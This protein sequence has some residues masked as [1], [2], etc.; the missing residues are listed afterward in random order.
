MKKRYRLKKWV[1]YFLLIIF[2]G[3]LIYS[4]I[5]ILVWNKGV[6]ENANTKEEIKKEIKV[7]ENTEKSGDVP[8]IDY[9]VNF[10]KLK[11][12]NSDAVGYLIVK[13]TNIDYVVVKAED[14]AYYLNHD[15]NKKNNK[16]GWIFADFKNKFDGN[17]KNIVIYGHNTA[18]GS[19]FGT[20]KN[21]FN[22]E[23]ND[24]LKEQNA[25]IYF[26]TSKGTEYYKIF[27]SYS[28]IPEDYYITTDFNS[29]S[30]YSEFLKTI[31]S[32]SIYS[33]G[34]SVDTNDT[35]LTLS[36]CTKNGTKRVAL[37]AKKINISE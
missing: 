29:T 33:Y 22:K 17:D 26:V 3:G 28:I 30:E 19:M 8:Q 2:I 5:N 11:E 35:I 36:T 20:L 7:V 15:F 32:R 24:S 10:T 9:V 1:I 31:K 13:N 23:W 25:D 16:V 14:N 34:V 12:K 27:S 4:V 6:K 21:V 37:H 18:D